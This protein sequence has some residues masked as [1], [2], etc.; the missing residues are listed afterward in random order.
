[1]WD[2]SKDLSIDMP[3]I[4]LVHFSEYSRPDFSNYSPKI[5][6]IFLVTCQFEYKGIPCT[7]TQF[8]LRLVYIITV[9]KS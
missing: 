5:I 1:M 2:V 7:R 6:P 8:P 3:S 9:Y 4:L